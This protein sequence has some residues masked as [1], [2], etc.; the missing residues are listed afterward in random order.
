MNHKYEYVGVV[1][2]IVHAGGVY[3]VGDCGLTAEKADRKF[4]IPLDDT[5]K[6]ADLIIVGRMN[7]PRVKITIELFPSG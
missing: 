4:Q 1:D 3:I 5:K 6:Y 7:P 2:R